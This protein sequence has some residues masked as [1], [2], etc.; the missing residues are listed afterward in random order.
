VASSKYSNRKVTSISLMLIPT[1]GSAA[2]FLNLIIVM[3]L[4]GKVLAV[5]GL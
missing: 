3:R 5:E 2:Y 1:Y 4:C